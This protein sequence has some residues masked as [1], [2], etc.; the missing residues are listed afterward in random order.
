MNTT[1]P[2]F[3]K[4]LNEAQRNA[5]I[6]KD[7]PQLVIAGAGSGK[8]RV[9][10]YKIAYL[11]TQGYK[12][13]EIM[14]LTFTNKAAKE[15]KARIAT[16]VGEDVARYLRMGTFHSVFAWLLRNEA[17]LVGY[18]SNFTIYDDADSRSL[19]KTIIKEMGLDDKIYKPS[20]IRNYIS[21]AKN[22]LITPDLYA[23][24]TT[25]RERDQREKIPQTYAIYNA[26]MTRCRNCNAMDFDD[27]LL[28]TYFLFYNHPDVC[29]TYAERFLYFLIDEYQ[30]T[31]KVQQ[32]IIQLLAS[33]HYHICAVGDD[34]QSIYAFRGANIDNILDFQNQYPNTKLYKLEQN[35][36]STKCIVEAANSLI[37]KNQRQIRKAVYSMGDEG[38]RIDL[39]QLSS[40]KEEALFVARDI[41]QKMRAEGLD[42]SDF[43]VL[44]RT[45]YQSRAFEEQF[46]KSAMPYRIY[47]GMSFYQRKEIKDIIAYFRLIVNHYDEEAL[48]RVINYPA[49]GIGN[50]TIDKIAIAAADNPDN[51]GMWDIICYPVEAGLNVNKATMTKL[52]NFRAMIEG[53]ADQ[54][55]TADAYELGRNVIK[56]SGISND[57]YSSNDAEYISKQEHVDEFLNSMHEF[58]ENQREQEEPATLTDFLHD[59]SLLSDR[60]DETDNAPKINLM[61]V[62]SAK[63]LEF[64]C[65]Y[66]VGLE[67]NIFPSQQSTSSMRALEEER[68]LLYVAI[69][70]AERYCHL[71]HAKMR[72]RYGKQEWAS[73]S[74]FIRDINAKLINTNYAESSFEERTAQARFAQRPHN[75]YGQQKDFSALRRITNYGSTPIAKQ[76][77]TPGKNSMD[78]NAEYNLSVGD[79]VRHDRFGQGT[80]IELEG[81]GS[82]SKATIDFKEVGKKTLLLS[83][84][85][86][87]VVNR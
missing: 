2:D 19:C 84:A 4:D 8:T 35:Y 5:V 1:E 86:L 57:I 11:L 73:Q 51:W 34:A 15:M 12:P 40:D 28:Y 42:Y 71:T 22:N 37:E 77:G 64:P 49:R 41:K 69:T 7:G 20:T 36:R 60:E 38:D 31:N 85:R 10:T 30:D 81:K 21:D 17:S 3:L 66:I 53:F 58:V 65:V 67:E 76:N 23:E 48:K 33:H 59:V 63:G 26:Y 70:R 47:G 80:V 82:S 68:R 75:T 29:K 50:T 9:L 13:W 18:N 44:Y 14:A 39:T 78:T 24:N 72:F 55:D 46:M 25:L 27:L 87:K 52:T 56:T 43:A 6:Y 16:L 32:Q 61:T 62:H 83:F 45:N 74:R 54:L 79:T